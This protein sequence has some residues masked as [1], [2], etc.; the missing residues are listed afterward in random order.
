MYRVYYARVQFPRVVY[1]RVLQRFAPYL[2]EAV[3]AADNLLKPTKLKEVRLNE[4]GGIVEGRV[5]LRK[6]ATLFTFVLYDGTA[7][8]QI[9]A[10]GDQ[11]KQ[12][13]K[14]MRDDECYRI[15]AFKTRPNNGGNNRTSHGVEIHLV[16]VKG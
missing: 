16:K 15:T 4:L 14:A 1:F 7:E 13:S 11:W 10:S 8:I 12:L 5:S 6:H 9:W 2:S 3:L